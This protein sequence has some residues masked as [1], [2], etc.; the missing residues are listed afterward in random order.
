LLKSSALKD[1]KHTLH[2]PA[3]FVV[4]FPSFFSEL[5]LDP[6]SLSL[7]NVSVLFD[8]AGELS[9]E[10][11]INDGLGDILLTINFWRILQKSLLWNRNIFLLCIII[12]EFG[13]L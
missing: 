6:L 10:S 9:T 5:I 1:F 2:D 12:T 13:S 3:L 7:S 4:V 11:G 8:C